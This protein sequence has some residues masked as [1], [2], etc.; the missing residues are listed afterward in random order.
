MK[1]HGKDKGMYSETEIRAH[2]ETRDR[3]VE[4][5]ILARGI[6]DQA[7]IAAM[8]T[9]PRH[10]F[11]SA[12]IQQE[13][14]LDHPAAI[15]CNQTISQPY[16]VAIMTEMIMLTRSSRVLE[17][18]TGSGYQTA[19]LAE[20]AGNVISIE[21]HAPLADSARERLQALGYDTVTVVIGDGTLGYPEDAPYDAIL[22]TAGA[23]EIPAGLQQ[24][25]ALN[26]RLVAPVGLRDVQQL[27]TI[28][29][30][31]DDTFTRHPGISCRFV[32]LI[33]EHGWR[34]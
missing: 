2:Q 12:N 4:Q 33:G 28:V 1:L 21:R 8:R 19:I 18:G 20:I 16:I 32:P 3:M 24:Q 25:L 22:I 23:P 9:V 15:A 34:E 10:L 26:G 31:E 17:I 7:V 13:A 27:V 6:R 14:Y 11:L 29:R 5:Q 30:E